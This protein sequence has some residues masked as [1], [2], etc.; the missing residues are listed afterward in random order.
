MAG[1]YVDLNFSMISHPVKKD[2]G[3]SVDTRAIYNSMSNILRTRFFERPF[4]NDLG[5]EDILFEQL[6]EMSL[7][8]LETGAE[9]AI[10]QWE[11]RVNII[12]ITA[13]KFPENN[14]Q[15]VNLKIVF[16]VVDTEEEQTAEIVLRQSD[17]SMPTNKPQFSLPER[18]VTDDRDSTPVYQI[19]FGES[20]NGYL[21]NNEVAKLRTG[22]VRSVTGMQVEFMEGGYK[23]FASPKHLVENGIRFNDVETPFDVSVIDPY[24]VNIGGVE[25]LVYRTT[26]KLGGKIRVRIDE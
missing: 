14:F 15:A 24:M 21:T 16:V 18:N 5:M 2:L 22:F 17:F 9:I 6:D 12:R 25:Y 11:P 8:K 26:N 13:S 19:F 1:R 3:V 10:A 7:A 23:Y 20:T 4:N